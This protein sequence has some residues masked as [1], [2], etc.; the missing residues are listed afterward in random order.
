MIVWNERLQLFFYF[1][2]KRKQDLVPE[3]EASD[4]LTSRRP[5]PSGSFRFPAIQHSIQSATP[6]Y[7]MME[8]ELETPVLTV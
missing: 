6:C 5:K 2:L 7:Q 3:T 1:D 8:Q 4:N